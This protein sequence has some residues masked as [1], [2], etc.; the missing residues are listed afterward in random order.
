ML[1]SCEF[2]G[3]DIKIHVHVNS[4]KDE[5]RYYQIQKIKTLNNTMPPIHKNKIWNDF[6][7]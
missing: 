5:P 2:V 3:L 7:N 1:K 6:V 4:I